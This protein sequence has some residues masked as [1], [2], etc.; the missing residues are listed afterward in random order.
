MRIIIILVSLI[1]ISTLNAQVPQS[2]NFQTII[3]DSEGKVKK[4]QLI[5]I[6]FSILKESSS[7]TAVYVETHIKSTNEYGVLELLIGSGTNEFGLFNEI[8]W[9]GFVHFLKTEIDPNGSSSYSISTVTQFMSVPYSL[10][11]GNSDTSNYASIADTVLNA[12]DNSDTNEIQ[13]LIIS[14]DS[15]KISKGN[16]ININMN[17][18]PQSLV[19][20]SFFGL[21]TNVV[22]SIIFISGTASNG[23]PSSSYQVPN[24]KIWYIVNIAGKFNFSN[25]SWLDDSD[26]LQFYWN[27]SNGDPISYR[28]FI[29][30]YD[31]AE[32]PL[33]IY[34]GSAP[35]G[36]C[37]YCSEIVPENK[38]WYI[39]NYSGNLTTEP[40]NGEFW[41]NEG[42]S[43][44][45]TGNSSNGS[46]IPFR[47]EIMEISK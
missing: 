11:S 19:P 16:V 44:S 36:Y 43:F 17:R 40:G 42:Q 6:R 29:I 8:D 20:T 5:R 18:F 21:N 27:T 7:G 25:G 37:D 3:R 22:D 32:I 12:P 33:K 13:E 38:L 45:F 9:G 46:S 23:G 4:N 1:C 35:W 30:Q 24:S 31:K 2:F 28:S 10:Y 14:N 15:L 26:V 41:L 34:K 39:L 47:I